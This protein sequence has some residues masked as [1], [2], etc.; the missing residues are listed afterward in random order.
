[1]TID[2]KPGPARSRAGRH[3]ITGFLICQVK[4]NKKN[5]QKF[6]IFH[7]FLVKIDR[8]FIFLFRYMLQILSFSC[9]S[10]SVSS[11]HALNAAMAISIIPSSGSLVVILWSQSPGAEITLVIALSY[12]PQSL[13]ISKPTPQ[14]TGI[15]RIFISI[16]TKAE[17]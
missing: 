5:D 17:S 3:F 10:F 13:R 7:K 15:Q 11:L 1:M 16:Q 8:F 9:V 2:R 12:F 6:V 4:N 14:V